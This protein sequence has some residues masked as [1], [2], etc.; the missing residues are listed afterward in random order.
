MA[1]STPARGP[2]HARLK[3]GHGSAEHSIEHSQAASSGRTAGDPIAPVTRE[4]LAEAETEMLGRHE[5]DPR[6]RDQMK[7]AAESLARRGA[8]LEK[9]N[10]LAVA[11]FTGPEYEIFAAELAAYGYPVLL[12]W[13]RRGVIYT[14]CMERGRPVKPTDA[15]KEILAESFDD[16]LD[17]ALETAARALDFFREHVLLVGRWSYEGGATL[18]TYFVG[19]CLFAFPNVFRRWQGEQRRW[20]GALAAEARICERDRAITGQPG[21]DPAD[22]AVGRSVVLEAL[23]QMPPETQA[24]AALIIDDMSFAEAA[25]LLGTT[26]R[27]IEGRLYRYRTAHAKPGDEKREPR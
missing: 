23:A 8:D 12:A 19:A 24:A 6:H 21:T 11:G 2:A 4:L 16:R 9:L 10:S 22:V 13:I 14:Y 1:S 20:R 18:T 3:P 27:S 26:D 25:S 17:L 15:D 5:L 7:K